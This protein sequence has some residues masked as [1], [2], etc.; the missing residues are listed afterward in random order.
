MGNSNEYLK[1]L[2]P[3]D[4]QETFSAKSNFNFSKLIEL[5]GLA[6][7][8]SEYTLLPG[9]KGDKGD[10][11][12]R[13]SIV[14]ASNSYPDY[15]DNINPLYRD[16]NYD[17]ST[18]LITMYDDTSTLPEWKI[19]IDIGQMVADEV[20]T[21]SLESA[22]TVFL[23]DSELI[24][25][26]NINEAFYNSVNEKTVVLNN[27][28]IINNFSSQYDK[29][30]D[31]VLTLY[32]DNNASKW[33]LIIGA[34][35]ETG[36]T[37]LPNIDD[38]LKIKLQNNDT[39][40]TATAYFDFSYILPEDSE[41]HTGFYFKTT[42]F[43]SVLPTASTQTHILLGSGAYMNKIVNAFSDLVN[44]IG[45]YGFTKTIQIGLL[46]STDSTIFSGA[47]NV[48]VNMNILPHTTGTYTLGSNTYKFQDLFI[49]RAIESTALFI[50]ETATTEGISYND[51]KIA[52]NSNA[53]LYTNAFT[54]KGDM[55]FAFVANSTS[56]LSTTD[57]SPANIYNG[58]PGM[59][60][61]ISAGKGAEASGA[62][63]A[64]QGGILYIRG[65]QGGSHSGLSSGASGGDLFLLGGLSGTGTGTPSTSSINIGYDI[66]ADVK[67]NVGI[68]N[69]ERPKHGLDIAQ[70]MGWS[71]SSLV[72][73]S[74][75]TNGGNIIYALD[76]SSHAIVYFDI[77]TTDN[78][79]GRIITIKDVGKSATAH[80][81]IVRV[82]G[83][84][85]ID[86]SSGGT[87][88]SSARI[89]VNNGY[90]MMFYR[91]SSKIWHIISYDGIDFS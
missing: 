28:D 35:P 57:A 79:D 91:S 3:N 53:S 50:G 70:D 68:N 61:N 40:D 65:G 2:T 78:I 55:D 27:F 87:L 29:L 11:G 6:D 24:V 4:S 76:N 72:T 30:K 59:G 47:T 73:S 1:T 71:V 36:T 8:G 89:Y 26:P 49:S 66:D 17:S 52:I 21:I 14:Y 23:N 74:A 69:R 82:N 18:G 80:P 85:T 42:N 84:S 45:I 12:T 10:D 39:F 75:S 31:S 22:L 25:Y 46:N 63:N 64:G 51:G 9:L 83:A 81:I 67:F 13:G 48:I 37:Y 58:G 90:L 56:Y 34:T 19:L 88:A 60:L 32:I 44:G 5:I 15:S 16:L 43:N 20:T 86:Y 77:D 33:N 38:A 7:V 62:Y 54:I 41:R